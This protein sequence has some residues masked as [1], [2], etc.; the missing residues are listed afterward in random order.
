MDILAAVG[1]IATVIGIIAG[2]VQVLEYLQKRR[3]KLDKT[4]EEKPS[5]PSPPVPQV[6]HNL[7]PR[8]DFIGR[9]AEK[10]RVHKALRSRY[11]LTS[12]DGIG[13]IGKTV[14]AL[15][16]AHECL[17]ASRGEG[18]TDGIVAFDGFIWTTAK[19]RDLT[20]NALLDAVARTLE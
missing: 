20:L 14:L 15:E 16:V 19:D 6:P 3:K 10:A 17:H 8:T 13:G 1:I 5:P 12:I 11:P 2:I 7:P 9:K 18:P 4:T